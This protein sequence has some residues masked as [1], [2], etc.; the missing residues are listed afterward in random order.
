MEL[1]GQSEDGRMRSG[2]SRRPPRAIKKLQRRTVTEEPA[3]CYPGKTLLIQRAGNLLDG[4]DPNGGG[5]PG[6]AP[7]SNAQLRALREAR[8]TDQSSWPAPKLIPL[9]R[10]LSAAKHGGSRS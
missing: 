9:S 1:Y 4:P 2:R 7:F 8:A 3:S 10:L 5:H 6:G